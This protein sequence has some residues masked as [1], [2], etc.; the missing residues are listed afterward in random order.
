MLCA[1]CPTNDSTAIFR[2]AVYLATMLLKPLAILQRVA[3]SQKVMH[4]SNKKAEIKN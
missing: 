4:I 3:K 2:M 1:H